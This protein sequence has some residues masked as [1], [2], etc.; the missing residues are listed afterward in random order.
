MLA[1][2]IHSAGAGQTPRSIL[3]PHGLAGV[4]EHGSHNVHAQQYRSR[5]RLEV[6]DESTTD[7]IRLEL[8]F[9]ALYEATAPQYSACFVE[10]A[11]FRRGL[12][13]QTVPPTDGVATCVRGSSGEALEHRP[14][15]DRAHSRRCG[16]VRAQNGRPRR[17]GAG[18]SA[19]QPT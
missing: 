4:D 17:R 7:P 6:L 13:S 10:G 11:W 15:R 2:I 19:S 5:R 1:L 3:P 12:P 8:D 18:G 9:S 16:A 14:S